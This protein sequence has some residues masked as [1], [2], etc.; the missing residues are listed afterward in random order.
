MKTLDALR[1]I[2]PT[3]VL[4]VIV[5]SAI[6]HICAT[7]AAPSLATSPAFSRLA[8]VLPLNVMKVLPPVTRSEQPLPFMAPD[9]LYAMCRF[10]TFRS[11]VSLSAM[12]PDPG[13]TLAIYT[14]TGGNIY[15][16][17]GQP[18]QP[19]HANI[20]LV[21]TGDIFTGLT[22]EARGLASAEQQPLTFAIRE[23]IAV[24]RAPNRGDAYR[25]LTE[26][27]LAK[28]RCAPTEN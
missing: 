15:V 21:P 10:D 5:A 11:P 7:L 9:A 26:A 2:D 18:L 20:R 16:V 4:A 19:T 28:A 27:A 17:S 23:G 3:S 13:W 22:A 8:P 24:V 25:G 6:L 12:L 1:N 14:P